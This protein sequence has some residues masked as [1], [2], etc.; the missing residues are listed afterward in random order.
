MRVFFPECAPDILQ[1]RQQENLANWQFAAQFLK[2]CFKPK[3][4]FAKSK[5]VL[6]SLKLI[7]QNGIK[8]AEQTDSPKFFL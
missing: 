2:S 3:L 7:F 4:I 8:I 6:Y 5:F 1:E